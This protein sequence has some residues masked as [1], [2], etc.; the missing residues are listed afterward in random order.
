M[1]TLSI[2][3]HFAHRTRRVKGD[4]VF[5]IGG[6]E[7]A[8]ILLFGFLIF[9]PDKMPQIART[10]GRAIRQ[11]RT[12]QE[13]MN[14]VIKAEVYD[15]LKDLE[16][17]ANPFAG[18]SLD[19]SKKA[20][21]TKK[22]TTKKPAAA[23]ETPADKSE[24]A[25]G[26]ESTK[27]PVEKPKVSKDALQSALVADAQKAREEAVKATTQKTAAVS[28]TQESFAQRRARLEKEHA[29]AKAA[30][31]T[32]PAPDAQSSHAAATTIAPAT[33]AAST[34]GKEEGAS[35]SPSS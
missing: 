29:K 28:A 9:G 16:P 11:F 10:I 27:T 3:L 4:C 31:A 2:G 34:N 1:Y 15:P 20:A 19:D 8:I 26:D 30:Q 23:K 14:K 22:P 21:S 17:L 32:G 35:V 24:D 25:I 33:P 7:I 6:T 5:G 12:A 18:L 13:Q